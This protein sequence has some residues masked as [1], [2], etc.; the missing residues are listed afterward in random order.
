MT[1]RDT[2]NAQNDSSYIEARSV[3]GVSELKNGFYRA[4]FG[5]KTEFLKNEVSLSE[6]K[7]K[8]AA[9][10]GNLHKHTVPTRLKDGILY[11]RVD[12]SVF[13]Q[14]LML[15]TVRIIKELAE[16]GIS[17]RKIVPERR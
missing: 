13:T 10:C 11:V 16:Y 9:V 4:L 5:D 15:N 14:E 17:I 7:A 8:W 1:Q 3:S 2:F 6:C 12:A